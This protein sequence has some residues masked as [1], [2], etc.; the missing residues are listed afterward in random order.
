MSVSIQQPKKIF[1]PDSDGEPMAENTL[2]FRWIVTIKEGLDA[3]YRNDPNVFVAGDLFWYPVEGRPD[4]R[5][6][7]D[8]L[9][10]FGRPRGDR[11]S[12][13][14]WEEGGI[15]PQVVFEVLSPSNRRPSVMMLK[16]QFYEKYG[17]QEYYF[18]DPDWNALEGWIRSDE[19]L[20]QVPS[21]NGWVSP[22]LGVRFDL[23]AG[24]LRIYGPDGRLFLTYAELFEEREHHSQQAERERARADQERQKAEQER[25]KAVQERIRADKLAAQLRAHGIEPEGE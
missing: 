22:L 6:A 16:H 1:Y 17:V 8:I 5:V 9:V 21:M 14:Q 11:L 20:I 3:A 23:D 25:Q 7:P 12:Y 18:Y 24:E 13:R 2:Q 10:V 19:R 4:I 15:A